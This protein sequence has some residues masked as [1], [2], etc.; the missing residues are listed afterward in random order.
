MIKKIKSFTVDEAV[1]NLVV[2]KFKGSGAEVSVS[3]FVTNCL[4]ELAEILERVETKLKGAKEYTVPMS[5]IIKLIVKNNDILGFK[6]DWLE[7]PPDNLEFIL[8]DWQTE[9]EAMQKK[10]PVEF[11]PYVESGL[12]SLSVNKKY[13][14]EKKTGERYIAVGKKRLVLIDDS[15]EVVKKT[16]K[17]I[18]REGVK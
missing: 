15:A 11:Y 14:I 12:Y 4:E 1:Y 5:F 16:I 18:K 6:K 8:D 3:M 13:L 17:S 10:I 7:G 2:K 9:Y